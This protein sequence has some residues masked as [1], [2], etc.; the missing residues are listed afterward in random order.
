MA[1]GIGPGALAMRAERICTAASDTRIFCACAPVFFCGHARAPPRAFASKAH[2]TSADQTGRNDQRAPARARAPLAEHRGGNSRRLH[3]MP[4]RR[5]PSANT[6]R[7][8]VTTL[9]SIPRHVFIT[10]HAGPRHHA[11]APRNAFK[12]PCVKATSSTIQSPGPERL[13]QN[14]RLAAQV[15]YWPSAH[16]VP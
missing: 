3:V 8:C 16:K 5:A 1:N 13:R 9:A 7:V 11:R 10:A 4:A 6:P 15:P 12:R 14:C 2:A